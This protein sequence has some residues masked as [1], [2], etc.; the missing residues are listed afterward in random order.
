MK[1]GIEIICLF[2]L[3]F[4]ISNCSSTKRMGLGEGAI[5]DETREVKKF[6]TKLEKAAISHD[7]D[8]LL[9]LIDQNYLEEQYYGFLGGDTTQFLNELFC[10]NYV[11]EKGFECLKFTEIENMEILELV[12]GN[13]CFSS[14][15]CYRVEYKVATNQKTV[16]AS[17]TI[18]IHTVN[19][20]KIY[21][22]EGA[23]G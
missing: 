18:T 11:D 19:G 21:G 6:L 5:S 20:K 10:G 4:T 13:D 8:K 22:L 17:W 3:V 23:Y 2:L 15:S 7:S 9:K 1:K 16:I 14:N 12:K